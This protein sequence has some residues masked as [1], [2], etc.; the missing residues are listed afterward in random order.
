MSKMRQALPQAITVPVVRARK[1]S[2]E[3][4][5]M[6]TAYDYP[7]ARI[8]ED[9]G[10]DVLLVGDSLGMVVQGRSDTL[11]VTLEQMVYHCTMVARAAKRALVVADMPFLTYQAGPRDALINCG[12]CL[13][14]GG[15]QAVKIEGGARRAPL[16]RRL[17]ENDIPVMGHI[18]LTPQ[19]LHALGGFKVQGRTL[20][21][22]E[23]LLKDALAL[24]RAGA[25]S[26]V[27]E[28]VPSEVAREITS[29]VRIPTIGIGAGPY[30]DGQVLV[31]HDLLGLYEG[32]LARFVRPYGDFGRQ[33]R[34]ALS[35]FGEDVR[36]G[37]FPT[38]EEAF[39]L[40]TDSTHAAAKK[41]GHGTP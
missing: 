17:V 40:Q 11:G 2:G 36:S 18:G 12:R 19:S 41:E 24:E 3:K 15:A 22:Q 32:H 38:E 14:E 8:A 10:V 21:A 4:V 33:M 25:F 1:A 16:V 35:H 28:C 31:F 23:Q 6:L 29:A 9:S 30:C 27:L 39:H 7:S 5:V 34:E 13:K 37:K 26:L 20:E